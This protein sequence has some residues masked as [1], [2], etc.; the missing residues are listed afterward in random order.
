MQEQKNSWEE[1]QGTEERNEGDRVQVQFPEEWVYCQKN[2]IF[3]EIL[4]AEEEKVTEELENH[5]WYM[6]LNVKVGTCVLRI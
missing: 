2:N 1:A 4:E 6:T 5:E 3:F